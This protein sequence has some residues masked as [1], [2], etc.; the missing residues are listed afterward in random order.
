MPRSTAKVTDYETL[1]GDLRDLRAFALAAD[2]RSLTG[3][4]RTSGESKA[5]VSRRITRLESS[6]GVA[7]LRRSTRGIEVTDE[8]AAYRLRV[9]EVLE[10]LG[11][12]N[13]AAVH[14]GRATPSG[15]LRVT[16][17]PGYASG[18][19][20]VFASFTAQYP[21]V[22]LVVNVSSRF[23]DLEAEHF[24]VALRATGKLADSSL[25]AVRLNGSQPEGS[26]VAAPS[27]LAAHLPP[28]RPQDLANHRFLALAESGGPFLLPFT[29][30]GTGETL[31]V[32]VP[33][34]LAGSDLGFLKEMALQ[35][36]GITVL[37]RINVQ[38][39]LDDGRL[40]HLLP[41]Y[42][43]PQVSL[44]VIHRGGPFVPPKVR[45]FVE[46]LRK[47]LLQK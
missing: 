8:G 40:V 15:Q 42:A 16:A 12:A 9:G 1:V 5:T 21:Q 44:F 23:V 13:A 25:V 18:L 39:E 38:R 46:H 37:P 34:A 43:W 19:A 26:V 30:R 7:L 2:L 14:G 17:A 28:R 31:H 24:D 3:S 32:T 4:A 29:R 27:Y 45:V 20:P 41:S 6:L 11:D 47:S 36:A 33:V 22:V 10:L 35:G